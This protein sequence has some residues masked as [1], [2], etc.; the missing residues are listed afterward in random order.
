MPLVE[1]SPRVSVSVLIADIRSRYG[2]TVGYH[3]AWYA[4]QKAMG[5]LFGDWDKS[6]TELPA[7]LNAMQQFHP[8]TIVDLQTVDAYN[9]DR[10]DA[11]KALIGNRKNLVKGRL[12]ADAE[13]HIRGIVER[14]V[15]AV[16][17][18]GRYLHYRGNG[19]CDVDADAVSF[20]KPLEHSVL[21]GV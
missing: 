6:Y 2:Y 21:N 15:T 9:G 1:A 16:E 17:R 5:R 3:K 19:A 8:G 20:I 13:R 11:V 18:F 12:T 10:L 14:L 4:K 7:W